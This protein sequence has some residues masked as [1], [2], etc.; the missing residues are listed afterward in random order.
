M[1]ILFFH[2]ETKNRKMKSFYDKIIIL[3]FS[4]VFILKRRKNLAVSCVKCS[5]SVR[6]C[7]DRRSNGRKKRKKNIAKQ[8]VIQFLLRTNI[9]QIHSK[10]CVQFEKHFSGLI[11]SYQP[12]V[13]IAYNNS[14]SLFKVFSTSTKREQ[15]DWFPPFCHSFFHFDEHES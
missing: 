5:Y 4:L 12:F 1:C 14:C 9:L 7:D 11:S 13:H 8:L 6:L 10:N 2:C 3:F 15:D